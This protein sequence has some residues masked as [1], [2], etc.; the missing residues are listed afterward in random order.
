M[1]DPTESV[2]D[3]FA[4]HAKAGL[5]STERGEVVTS[6]S[7]AIG[8]ADEGLRDAFVP[9]RDSV[10]GPGY[11]AAADAFAQACFDAGWDG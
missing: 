4:A 2:C 1:L 5:P 3:E 11:V 10:D 6:I 8:N 9:L 7:K